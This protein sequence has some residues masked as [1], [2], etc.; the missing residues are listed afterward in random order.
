MLMP[1]IF[2]NTYFNDFFEDPFKSLDYNTSGLMTTDVK[3]TKDGYEM[4]MCIRDS[5]QI[6]FNFF[7]TIGLPYTIYYPLLT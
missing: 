4:K 3:D 7:L 2:T 6:S 5:I 1:N